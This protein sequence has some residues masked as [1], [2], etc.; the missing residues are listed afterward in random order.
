MEGLGLPERTGLVPLA[1]LVGQD[2]DDLPRDVKPGVV[3]VVEIRRRDPVAGEDDLPLGASRLGEA[4]RDEGVA[5]GVI[6][7]QVSLADPQAVRLPEADSGHD[8][9]PLEV[10]VLASRAKTGLAEDLGD[11]VGC[12]IRPGRPCGSPGHLRGRQGFDLIQKPRRVERCVC[13]GG[14][15]SRERMTGARAEGE[16]D[17][18]EKN[19][20]ERAGHPWPGHERP[21]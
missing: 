12:A 20:H 1:G 11:V 2:E 6:K 17:C 7:E 9:E 3:V 4:E 5:H 21:G 13:R 18:P 14:G 19:D 15:R 8:L 16:K 10:A